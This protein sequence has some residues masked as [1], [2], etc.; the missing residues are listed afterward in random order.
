MHENIDKQGLI[1]EIER[2]IESDP[3]APISSFSLISFLEVG[4]LLAI[5]ESLLKSKENRSAENEKWFDASC[6]K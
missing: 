2:L 4:D 1:E 3:N 6:Q 5:K